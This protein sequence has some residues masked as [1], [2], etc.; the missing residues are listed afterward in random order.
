KTEALK[1][2]QAAVSS[3]NDKFLAIVV[4]NRVQAVNTQ[5]G[6]GVGDRVL[7]A[8]AEHFKSALS[9]RDQVF[10]WHGAAV[11]AVLEREDLLEEVRAEVRRSAGVKLQ[12]T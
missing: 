7:G 10:R 12:K 8:F 1:A 2:I 4:V 5:F 6:Y 9:A 3:P 11:I